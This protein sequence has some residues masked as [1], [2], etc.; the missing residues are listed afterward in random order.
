MHI[1]FVGSGKVAQALVDMVD[2]EEH[3]IHLYARSSDVI[4]IFMFTTI[5]SDLYSVIKNKTID[6]VID[7]LAHNDD[8]LFVS[9]KIIK[10]SL[11][12]N[13]S[14]ITANKKL[15][16]RFG[17]ELCEHAKNTNDQLYINSI[18]ASSSLFNAYPVYLS[19]DNFKKLNNSSDLFTYR[20]AGPK[21]TAEAINKEIK[22]IWKIKNAK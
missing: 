18:V 15:M 14:V 21:E 12:N 6:L 8:A 17:N 4:D 19:I 11:S 16:R 7:L 13:K 10:D 2:T 20:G 22:K 5:S 3:N 9:K 1:A